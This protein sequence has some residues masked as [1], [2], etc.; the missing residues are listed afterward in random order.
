M[1]ETEP[2]ARFRSN[3]SDEVIYET[4]EATCTCPGFQFRG[5]CSHLKAVSRFEKWGMSVPDGILP[6]PVAWK[7]EDD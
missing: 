2:K 1:G 6:P 5:E 4:F 7:V 3:K